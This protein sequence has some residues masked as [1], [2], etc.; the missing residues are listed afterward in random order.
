MKQGKQVMAKFAQQEAALES[1]PFL[2][3]LHTLLVYS[4]KKKLM[5]TEGNAMRKTA[6]AGELYAR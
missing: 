1:V 2:T 6:C 4:P 5:Q 3:V